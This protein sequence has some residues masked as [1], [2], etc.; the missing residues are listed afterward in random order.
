[1][2]EGHLRLHEGDAVPE[3]RATA[4]NSGRPPRV[5]VNPT[6]RAC[7]YLVALTRR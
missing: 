3:T 6:H 2:L 7:R 4:S 1:V 5:Y